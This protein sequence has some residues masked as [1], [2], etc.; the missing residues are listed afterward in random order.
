MLMMLAFAQDD[1]FNPNWTNEEKA[2][3][4]T[5]MMADKLELSEQQEEKIYAINLKYT[6]Q[7]KELKSEGDSFINMR[8]L[9]AMNYQKDGEV[10]EVLHQEQY[11]EYLILKQEMREK[12]KERRGSDSK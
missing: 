7:M 10:K 12:M 8:K 5:R 9:R 2:E 11:D 4:Q 3:F 1:S 6:E